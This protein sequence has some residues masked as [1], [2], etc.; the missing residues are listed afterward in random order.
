MLMDLP[1]LAA[2]KL[3]VGKLIERTE[4]VEQHHAGG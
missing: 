3:L 4:G 1:S 2:L